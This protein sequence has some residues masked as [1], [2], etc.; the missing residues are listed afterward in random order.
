M[1]HEIK[2]YSLDGDDT[3]TITDRVVGDLIVQNIGGSSGTF[4][5]ATVPEKTVIVFPTNDIGTNTCE[6]REIAPIQYNG[7]FSVW[8]FS[9]YN[10]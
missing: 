9:P 4:A 7:E 5:G 8:H 6:T 10:G 3:L 2:S 1:K